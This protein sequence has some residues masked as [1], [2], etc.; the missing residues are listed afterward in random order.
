MRAARWREKSKSWMLTFAK[1]LPSSLFTCFLSFFSLPS[2]RSKSF[3]VKQSAASRF[4]PT[5][6]PWA[7]E[8]EAPSCG[9]VELY[10]GELGSRSRSK[11]RFRFRFQFGFRRVGKEASEILYANTFHRALE[12][13]KGIQN[14]AC[15]TNRCESR[16]ESRTHNLVAIFIEKFSIFCASNKSIS[17]ST[18]T[19]RILIWTRV[20]QRG[21]N[22][23]FGQTRVLCF[24]SKRRLLVSPLPI[25]VRSRKFS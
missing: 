2:F 17:F 10:S 20:S 4:A 23:T 12:S 1:L 6:E 18:R 25:S 7:P 5:S 13:T 21:T 22:S 14:S 11:L 15:K 9:L 19:K 24:V 8:F 16:R 3:R